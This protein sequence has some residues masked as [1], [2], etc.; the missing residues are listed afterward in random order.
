M[1]QHESAKVKSLLLS[2]G[3][4]DVSSSEDVGWA[5]SLWPFW[6]IQS[7]QKVCKRPKYWRDYAVSP[8]TTEM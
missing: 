7:A 6:K 2:G 1:N 8:P 5:I 3:Y 4:I